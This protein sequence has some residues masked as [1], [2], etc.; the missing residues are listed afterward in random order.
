MTQYLELE[1]ELNGQEAAVS[2]LE[3]YK[4]DPRHAPA[5]HFAYHFYKTYVP[6]STEQQLVELEVCGGLCWVEM[7]WDVEERLR[8]VLLVSDMC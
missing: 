4:S 3:K 5:H 8:E 7:G 2:A 1:M 6:D